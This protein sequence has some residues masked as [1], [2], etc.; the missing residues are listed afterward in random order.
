MLGFYFFFAYEFRG[1]GF[2]LGVAVF[3]SVIFG[4]FR[5]VEVRVVGDR[6][7]VVGGVLCLGR[8]GIVV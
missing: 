2:G 4:C 7:W 8:F 3:F 5:G 1:F 6:F